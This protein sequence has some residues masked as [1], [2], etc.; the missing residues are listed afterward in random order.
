MKEVIPF[1]LEGV[2]PSEDQSVHRIR[3]GVAM[4]RPQ[5]CLILSN[6]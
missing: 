5:S 4:K 1:Y 3:E 6:A 2:V